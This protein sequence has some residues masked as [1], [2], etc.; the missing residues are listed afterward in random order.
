LGP[1]HEKKRLDRIRGNNRGWKKLE[2]WEEERVKRR[3]SKTGTLSTCGKKKVKG[4]L[5]EEPVSSVEKGT[6][7]RKRESHQ[8]KRTDSNINKPKKKCSPKGSA[9]QES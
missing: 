5:A 2:F 9:T 3:S 7:R 4:D 8:G 6:Q 1:F